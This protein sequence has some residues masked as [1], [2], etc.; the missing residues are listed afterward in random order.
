MVRTQTGLVQ[1]ALVLTVALGLSLA[2]VGRRP[3]TAAAL[4]LVVTTVDLAVANAHVVR[5]VPQAVMDS[6]P[7]VVSILERAERDGTVRRLRT[8]P[9]PAIVRP[10]PAVTPNI[11]P[12]IAPVEVPLIAP[13]EAAAAAS[14]V[15]MLPARLDATVVAGTAPDSQAAERYRAL[16]TRILHADHGVGTR[17]LLVTLPEATPVHEPGKPSRIA[18]ST[19]RMSV[20]LW[21]SS[22]SGWI[23]APKRPYRASAGACTFLYARRQVVSV[24]TIAP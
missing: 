6:T 3:A 24:V 19:I 1:A 15:R 13:E 20:G 17:V 11:T 23:I 14:T 9:E 7:E 21:L 8:N 5:T 12:N 16:R 22:E 10:T 4:A 18:L 2:P